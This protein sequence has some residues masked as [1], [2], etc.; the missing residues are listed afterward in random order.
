MANPKR[1][2][3][4]ITPKDGTF[5][6][7]L[8]FWILPFLLINAILFF[9]LTSQPKFEVTVEDPGDYQTANVIV[10]IKSFFPNNGVAAA[11]GGEPIE[12]KETEKNTYEAQVHTNGTV[13]VEVVNKNG[14]NKIVYETVSCIDDAPPTITEADRATGFVSVYIEDSQAGV[15]FDSVYA[16]DSLG[17]T[18]EPSLIDEGESLVAFYYDANGIEIHACDKMGKET[19][20]VFNNEPDQQ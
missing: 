15:D 9:A 2:H 3:K 4:T 7:L 1:G 18:L 13:T 10:K 14:M 6:S 19:I 5:V 12:L 16:Y 11:L 20:A 8:L 17:Q